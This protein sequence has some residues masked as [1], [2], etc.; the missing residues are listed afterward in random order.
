MKQYA[1]KK[2]LRNFGL[3]WTFILLSIS[4]F[5]FVKTKPYIITGYLAL[6]F[7][8]SAITFPIILKPFY[9]IWTKIGKILGYINTKIIL[10]IIFFAVFTPASFILKTLNK[11]LLKKKLNKNTKSYWEPRSEQPRS[12]IKQF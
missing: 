2:E 6:F 10:T 9:V 3:A 4:I 8:I 12:M 1:I 5:M 11:D 7:L